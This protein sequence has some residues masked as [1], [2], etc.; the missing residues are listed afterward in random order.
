MNDLAHDETACGGGSVEGLGFCDEPSSAEPIGILLDE[1][2]EER[3]LRE[4]VL[5]WVD[6]GSRR[7]GRRAKPAHKKL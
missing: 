5:Y 4:L 2:A 3:F 6:N 1:G 7:S